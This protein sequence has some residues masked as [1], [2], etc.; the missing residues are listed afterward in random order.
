ERDQG[1]CHQ[2]NA[3]HPLP[4]SAKFPHG[5]ES[6]AAIPVST[7]HPDS[8]G[9]K[10]AATGRL[11]QH[12]V[13]EHLHPGLP[14]HR[15]VGAG[16][17]PAQSRAATP[18]ATLLLSWSKPGFRRLQACGH[19]STRPTSRSRAPPSRGAHSSASGGRLAACP[20]PGRLAK[21]VEQ[22]PETALTYSSAQAVTGTQLQKRLRSPWTLSTRPTGGQYFRRRR[23]GTGKAAASRP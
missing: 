7:K 21:P 1:P 10:P 17:Q 5:S 8:A 13:P 12:L 3:A 4:D 14:T 11:A 20:K 18:G 22:K 16:L 19:G 2:G 6:T 9:Y 15:P 23:S